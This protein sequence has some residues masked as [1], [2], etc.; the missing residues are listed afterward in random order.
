MF[1]DIE[2]AIS[3]EI[4]RITFFAPRTKDKTAL[5]DTFDPFTGE[6]IQTPIEANYYDSSADPN[7]V[8]YPHFFV[9][10][11]KSKEDLTTGRVVPEYGKW[12][13]K[14]NTFSPGAYEIVSQAEAV[15]QAAGN[16][17]LTTMFQINKIQPGYLIRLLAGDNKG[18]YIVSS[19]TPN[20][21]GDH[22]I[23]VSNQLISSLPALLFDATLRQVVLQDKADINTVKVGDVFTDA[24]SNTFNITAVDPS[25]GKFVI[26][27][28]TDPDLA[29]GGSVSRTGDVFTNTDLSLVRFLILD[30]SKPVMV[31]NACGEESGAS[32]S[33]GVSPGIPLDVY[34]LVRIDS[35]ERQSHIEV[36]NRMWEEFNPPRTALPL[37]VRSS[38]SAEQV[39]TQDIASG[40]TD[41][42]DV[43]SNN[44][45]SVG[46]NVYLI[47][48]LHPTKR[49][50]GEGFER[51][52]ESQV[53]AKIGT[54]Q[55]Q[56]ADSVP[57]TYTV[58]NGAKIVSNAAFRLVMFHFVDHV[59]KDVEGS[60]Y[61]VHEFTFWVQVV[62]DR[63]ETPS[64]ST[65]VTGTGIQLE[66][67]EGNIIDDL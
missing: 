35:K 40:G 43:G 11:L 42:V 17:I 3:R 45:F 12:E 46:D 60:Q 20:M 39:L 53:I 36:L 37:I 8:Q 18:T 57:D 34:Y 4:R 58:A 13:V 21:V 61:W 25:T 63:L 41:I 10:L 27:G 47:D 64:D 23:T 38:L 62:I 2:E 24:S 9:R 32:G 44:D 31:N 67:F 26:D 50:D 5:Q 1:Y 33:S 14:P 56:L 22:I 29:E 28:S 16:D 19:V 49:V 59:T 51:P 48:D 65:A 55:L 7:H 15:I 54:N 52:F 66:D 30:P 6:I